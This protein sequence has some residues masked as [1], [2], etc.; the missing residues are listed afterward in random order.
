MFLA[1]TIYVMSDNLALLP[2]AQPQQPA[3]SAIA[4]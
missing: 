4:K 3:S 1:I 2:S